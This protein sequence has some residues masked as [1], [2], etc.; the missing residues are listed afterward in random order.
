MGTSASYHPSLKGKPEWG[1]LSGN[2]T[3][4][5][6]GQD[7]DKGQLENIFGKYVKVIGGVN[8]ASS[9]KSAV[10]GRAG[11][12]SATNLGKFLGSFSSSGYNIEKSLSEIGITDLSTKNLSDIINHLIEYC[13]GPASSIDD[14]AAK[15]ATKL[16]LEEI[17]ERA[18]SIDTFKQQL[19]E[20][21]KNEPLEEIIIKYFGYYI[22]EHLSV[23]F[24]EKLIKEKGE[25]KRGKLF[26]EIKD[27]IQESLKSVN[28][29]NPLRSLNWG[30]T[31]AKELINKIFKN[32]LTVFG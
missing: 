22:F 29:T 17:I 32:V 5:C 25:S 19:E 31:K 12:R 11:I 18:D 8:N 1:D 14:K 24:Y 20:T 26:K 4:G 2:V 27:F 21:L 7:L 15:E 3:R 10:M 13:S 30:S 6:N 9:G 23:M 16:L 28:K